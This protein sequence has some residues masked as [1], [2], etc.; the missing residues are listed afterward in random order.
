MHRPPPTPN[1]RSKIRIVRRPRPRLFPPHVEHAQLNLLEAPSRGHEPVS[2][3]AH[4]NRLVRLPDGRRAFLRDA[5]P[6]MDDLDL[7]LIHEDDVLSILER[8][9]PRWEV[10][11]VLAPGLHLSVGEDRGFTH[12]QPS[13]GHRSFVVS[14]LLR[15]LA[16][17]PKPALDELERLQRASA[18][19]QELLPATDAIH[20]NLVRA[21]LYRVVT[22]A[23]AVLGDGL[24]RL[25]LPDA[26]T[27]RRDADHLLP[28]VDPRRP[29]VLVHGDLHDENITWV[30]RRQ[31]NLLDFERCIA[32]GDPAHDLAVYLKRGAHGHQPDREVMLRLTARNTP[33]ERLE[34]LEAAERRFR[35]AEDF[36][37]M[38]RLV[39]REVLTPELRGFARILQMSRAYSAYCDGLVH[40]GRRPLSEAEYRREVHRARA[41]ATPRPAVQAQPQR[42]LSPATL[43]ALGPLNQVKRTRGAA[44]P[45]KGRSEHGRPSHTIRAAAGRGTRAAALEREQSQD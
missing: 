28:L 29:N 18:A 45:V 38:Y 3:V 27:L 37:E 24:D 41:L 35:I 31:G 43:A 40:L 25:G 9:S 2:G 36:G 12:R 1:G 8:C 5:Q 22:I 32:N 6:E 23:E 16:H 19:A 30:A 13:T 15:E 10:P 42:C 17:V 39:I 20:E 4:V 11:R 7:R 26:D 34:R 33:G 44:W 14:H 21:H